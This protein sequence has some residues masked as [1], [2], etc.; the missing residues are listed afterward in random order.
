M[1][2]SFVLAVSLF[3][4]RQA[5]INGNG[6]SI[7]GALIHLWDQGKGVSSG[8][9]TSLDRNGSKLVAILVYDLWILVVGAVTDSVIQLAA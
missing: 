4:L 9:V 5:A 6:L 3:T 7:S 8:A 1:V 2:T